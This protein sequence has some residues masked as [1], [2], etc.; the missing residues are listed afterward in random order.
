MLESKAVVHEKWWKV[1]LWSKCALHD[2][3]NMSK[4]PIVHCCQWA[5]TH[6]TPGSS[7]SRV[8]ISFSL[9][10]L[11]KKLASLDKGA[12]SRSESW[13]VLPAVLSLL[14][15][16]ACRNAKHPNGRK[17]W[18]AWNSTVETNHVKAVL[19]LSSTLSWTHKSVSNGCASKRNPPRSCKKFI[20][21]GIFWWF[22]YSWYKLVLGL[23]QI[24]PTWH[25]NH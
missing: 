20:T 9:D 25:V 6:G 4:K 11:N 3:Q 24:W 5:T 14:L 23:M 2:V 10:F 15:Q 7:I 13:K 22:A 21:W 16:R 12:I 17:R 18:W 8:S 19:T 1:K